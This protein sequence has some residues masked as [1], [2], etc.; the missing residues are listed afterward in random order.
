M[1]MHCLL[2]G[3]RRFVTRTQ[4]GSPIL[5]DILEIAVCFPSEGI[6]LATLACYT[7]AVSNVFL[8]LQNEKH[9]RVP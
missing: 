6:E 8:V 7:L 2:V 1:W 9:V 5:G 3:L 4:G